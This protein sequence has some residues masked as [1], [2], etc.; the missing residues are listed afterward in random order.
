[1]SGL[2][3]VLYRVRAPQVVH[4]TV[5]G[6]VVAVDFDTGSYYSLRGPAEAVWAAVTHPAPLPTVVSRVAQRFHGDDLETQTRA[7]LD[8]LVA[9]GLVE[10]QVTDQSEAPRAN[11]S[12]SQNAAPGA[13]EPLGELRFEKFTDM[14]EIILLD[15]VHDVSTEGWPHTEPGG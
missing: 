7:F 6:E 13:T 11:G 10:R 15:P 5:D 2:E 3:Q 9:E 1:M 14:E 8:Q 12:A 4:E